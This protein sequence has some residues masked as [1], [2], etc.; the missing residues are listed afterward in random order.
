MSVESPSARLVAEA[1]AALSVTDRDGRLI[2]LR[3]VTALDRLRLF[4][5]VGPM[6]NNAHYLG[7]A[8]LAC[9][10][11]AVDG[12]PIPFPASEQMIEAAVHRL[13]DARTSTAP[14]VDTGPGRTSAASP[15]SP[16]RS[17]SIA[18]IT[19]SNASSPNFLAHV[20]TPSPASLA[21]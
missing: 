7:M 4:R 8:M 1:N 2:E 9:A 18:A 10:V 13:G 20:A 12:V 15:F 21:V 16:S 11:T 6:A 5:A 17:P 3:Q 19:V 14:E